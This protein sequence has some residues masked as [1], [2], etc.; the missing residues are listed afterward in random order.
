MHE[1]QPTKSPG[2]VTVRERVRGALAPVTGSVVP[3]TL[4]GALYLVTGSHWAA[5]KAT[6]AAWGL[7][8]SVAALAAP[9]VGITAVAACRYLWRLANPPD[10]DRSP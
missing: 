8:P 5:M 7:A 1:L 9:I 6:V 10:N 4:V 3:G 2:E